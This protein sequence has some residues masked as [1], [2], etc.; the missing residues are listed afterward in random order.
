[1]LERDDVRAA[2]R[3]VELVVAQ[4]RRLLHDLNLV[5]FVQVIDHDLEHEPVELRLRQ[6]ICALELDRILRREDEEGLV[7]GVCLSLHGHP[8]LLHCF[9]QRRLRLRRRTVDLVGEYDVGEDRTLR[10][11]HVSPARS[12]VLNDLG[13]G[14]VARHQVGRELDAV[15]L[16]IDDLCNRMNQE[17]LRESRDAD[18]DAV[19]SAQDRSQNEVDHPLLSHDELVELREDLIM[20]HLEPVGERDVAGR[21]EAG[22]GRGNESH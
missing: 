7:E 14:D 17:G 11:Y 2:Y 10:E 18:D 5:R 16:E 8:M 1:M 3:F 6:R 21:I 20:A 13:A 19:S 22:V 15:E 12:V 9:E 4:R